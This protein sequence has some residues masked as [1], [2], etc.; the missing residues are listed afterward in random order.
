MNHV[1]RRAGFTLVEVI[2]SIFILS[3]ISVAALGSFQQ[4][5]RAK[6]VQNKHE[7]ILTS[8]SFAYTT[9]LNDI[10]QQV[11]LETPMVF[12]ERDISF[13]RAWPGFDAEPDVASIQYTW[14]K[15]NLQREMRRGEQNISQTL[16]KDIES[17]QWQWLIETNWN[18]ISVPVPADKTVRAL[19]LTFIDPTLGE[20]S[21][22]FARP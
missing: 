22:I 15:G 2:I 9:L 11:D 8:L 20:V 7:A 4:M 1:K 19:K 18:D 10:T 13:M 17:L 21:W 12:T 3:I 14:A 6:E 16:L 5:I